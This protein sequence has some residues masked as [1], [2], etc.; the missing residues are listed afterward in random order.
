M[1]TV[2]QHHYIIALGSNRPHGRHGA[3]RGV[4]AAALKALPVVT[5]SRIILSRPIGPSRRSYANAVAH[6]ESELNPPALL[7][8]LKTIEFA[9]GR[10]RGQRWGARVLDLDIIFWSGGAWASKNLS[11]PHPRF[12]ER[13]F[14][15]GP[16]ATIT[17]QWRDPLTRLS[18]KQ[19]KARLDRARACP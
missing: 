15:L 17:P 13:G 11:I 12:D 19:L 6:I 1:Q 8:W 5:A 14:V 7:A 18:V 9:F 10:R 3:P 4:I 16:L 2:F